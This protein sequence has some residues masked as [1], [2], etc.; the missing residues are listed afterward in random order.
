MSDGMGQI[1]TID[2]SNHSKPIKEEDGAELSVRQEQTLCLLIA[3]EGVSTVA[4]SVQVSRQTVHRWLRDPTFSARLAARRNDFR[5]E[6]EMNIEEIAS[7]AIENIGRAVSAGNVVVS[8]SVVK[9]LGLLNGVMAYAGSEVPEEIRGHQIREVEA[10]RSEL[11][12]L[13]MMVRGRLS[14]SAGGRSGAPG[15]GRE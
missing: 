9:G 10:A 15:T 13:D 14:F 3:G 2:A 6:L 1:V 7:G 8:L 4:K 5:R 12:A 11:R